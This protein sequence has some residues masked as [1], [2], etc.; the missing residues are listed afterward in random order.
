MSKQRK[1]KT[2]PFQFRRR[3]AAK[4]MITDEAHNVLSF[5]RG[6]Y[7]VQLLPSCGKCMEVVK[8][9]AK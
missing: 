2:K 3:E 9:I 8:Q 7:A 4:L 5:C 1:A 6:V